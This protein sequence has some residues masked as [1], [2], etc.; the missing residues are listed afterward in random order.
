MSTQI[1][2]KGRPVTTFN[3]GTVTLKTEDF[4]L[5]GDIEVVSE[6]RFGGTPEEYN[7]EVEVEGEARPMEFYNNEV[8]VEGEANPMEYYDGTVVVE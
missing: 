2:Y 8:N 7:G 5:E 4:G 1:K 3:K 6:G